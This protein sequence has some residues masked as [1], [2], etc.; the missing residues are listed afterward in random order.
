MDDLE[1]L[2]RAGSGKA[3][4]MKR[5]PQNDNPVAAFIREHRVRQGMTQRELAER[6]SIPLITLRS[7]EQGKN[8]V[9]MDTLN[10]LL[11]YFAYEVGAVPCRHKEA[12]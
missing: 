6:A 1:A 10:R 7:I 9:R 2:F 4:R 8:T 12:K 11:N 3:R 5:L